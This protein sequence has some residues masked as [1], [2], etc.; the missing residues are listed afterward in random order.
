M[1][2]R[3]IFCRGLYEKT[4]IFSP[5]NKTGK[6]MMT[7]SKTFHGFFNIFLLKKHVSETN[8]HGHI[9]WSN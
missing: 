2:I 9:Q 4:H 7:I 6:G 3:K 1:H 5:C 8:T